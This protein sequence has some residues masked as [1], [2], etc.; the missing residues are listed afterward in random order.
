MS[1][2]PTLCGTGTS[3]TTFDGI[4]GANIGPGGTTKY[5]DDPLQ[6]AGVGSMNTGCGVLQSSAGG[7]II[8]GPADS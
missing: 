2:G 8:I 1:R 4:P 6:S 3:G 5:G 7:N